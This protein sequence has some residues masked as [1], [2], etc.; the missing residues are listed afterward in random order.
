MPL[1]AGPKGLE[2]VIEHPFGCPETPLMCLELVIGE[3]H[4][5]VCPWEAGPKPPA[6]EVPRP[7]RIL[8]VS[9][10]GPKWPSGLL[11]P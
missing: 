7:R 5:L 6:I 4:A 11:D 8:P 9:L 2:L 3:P 10:G 1:S